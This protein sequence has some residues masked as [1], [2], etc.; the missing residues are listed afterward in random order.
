MVADIPARSFQPFRVF[1]SVLIFNRRPFAT[2]ILDKQRF[3]MPFQGVGVLFHLL[4]KVSPGAYGGLRGLPFVADS[5][6]LEN[7][8]YLTLR[9][10]EPLAPEPIRLVT[11]LLRL[12]VGAHL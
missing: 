12:Y 3:R 9:H 5:S 8:G 1:R 2:W 4:Y 6:A 7:V 10:T 11:A